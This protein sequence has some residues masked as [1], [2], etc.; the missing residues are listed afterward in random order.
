LCG[1]VVPAPPV[2]TTLTAAEYTADRQFRFN[3]AGQVGA[4]YV[5]QAATNPNSASWLPLCTNTAPF[6]FEDRTAAL[7]PIRFYRAMALP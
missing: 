6:T 4:Q 3:V 7:C 5:I 2:P 1:S